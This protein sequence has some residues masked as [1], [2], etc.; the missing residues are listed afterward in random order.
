MNASLQFRE[1]LAESSQGKIGNSTAKRAFR[2]RSIHD[3][4]HWHTFWSV[5]IYLGYLRYSVV[6]EVTSPV[7]KNPGKD[8]LPRPL[9]KLFLNYRRS[10]GRSLRNRNFTVAIFSG[11]SGTNVCS[12]LTASTSAN[13]CESTNFTVM[14]PT[15]FKKLSAPL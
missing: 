3:C 7:A 4:W 11:S 10:S 5:G 8:S 2:P 13:S 15:Y 1:T 12:R 14:R 9:R 6:D